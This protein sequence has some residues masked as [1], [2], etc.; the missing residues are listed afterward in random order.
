MI[1]PSFD[2]VTTKERG[3]ELHKNQTKSF[4]QNSKKFFEPQQKRRREIP[5]EDSIR[6]K[7]KRKKSSS[8]NE[9]FDK[10]NPDLEQQSLS[11]NGTIFSD[12]YFSEC[13]EICKK[14]RKHNL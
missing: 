5:F 4:K 1:Q 9:I 2:D 12:N 3:P 11:S 14:G 10:H 6:H 8:L 7:F 13:S